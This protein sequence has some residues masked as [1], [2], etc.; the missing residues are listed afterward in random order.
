MADEVIRGW[1]VDRADRER[2]LARFPPRYERVVADHVT[3]MPGD[4]DAPMPRVS[5]GTVVGRADDGRGV[6]ALVVELD[7]ST[8]RPDG[9]TWHITWSLGAGREAV[10]SNAVIAAHGWEEVERRR[11][12]LTE[13]SWP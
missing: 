8:E 10:E 13:A 9:S 1:R 5:H 4:A 3:F 11:V 7:G 6:D 12:G 2:L